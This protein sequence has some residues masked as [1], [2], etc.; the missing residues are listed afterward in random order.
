MSYCLVDRYKG[1][2]LGDTAVRIKGCQNVWK[3]KTVFSVSNLCIWTI[4]KCKI[5]CYFLNDCDF[6]GRTNI[7]TS[8]EGSYVQRQKYS[9]CLD[10]QILTLKPKSVL[11][12]MKTFRGRRRVFLNPV[13]VFKDKIKTPG[14]ISA[15]VFSNNLSSIHTGS[16][17]SRISFLI[18]QATLGY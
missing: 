9:V 15:S 14:E 17:Y 8:C 2:K 13:F 3:P 16:S 12:S 5:L 4:N 1:H 7:L 6:A 11:N 10:F 18:R